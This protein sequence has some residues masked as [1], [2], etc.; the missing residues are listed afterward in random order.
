MSVE[1]IPSPAQL[2]ALGRLPNV[3]AF[4]ASVVYTA[5]VT[6]GTRTQDVAIWSLGLAEDA[7]GNPAPVR[8]APV[9]WSGS[10]GVASRVASSSRHSGMNW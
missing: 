1:V 7:A 3:T 9:S 8:K 2:D 6:I 4:D 10:A 5:R